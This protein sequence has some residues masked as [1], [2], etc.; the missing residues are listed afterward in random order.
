MYEKESNFKMGLEGYFT[1][2]QFLY[3]GTKTPTYWEFGFMVEKTLWNN[4][5]F[6]INFENFTDTRQVIIKELSMILIISQH[7]MI[8][9]HIQKGLL[10]TEV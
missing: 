5:A 9:G 8:S 1:D 3:N 10:L 7:L 4:F 6:F 2:E